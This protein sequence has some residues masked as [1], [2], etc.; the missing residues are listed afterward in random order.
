MPGFWTFE[1]TY[2]ALNKRIGDPNIKKIKFWMG[3]NDIT[4][5][6]FVIR[7][8]KVYL[9]KV[10]LKKLTCQPFRGPIKTQIVQ[11]EEII[12]DIF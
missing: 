2:F 1:L 11:E 6:C 5:G 7:L 9:D 12:G 8:N 10:A 3:C 4:P